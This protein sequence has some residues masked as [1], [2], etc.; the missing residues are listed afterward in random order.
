MSHRASIDPG[1]AGTG[2]CIWEE[3]DW[4]KQ[5]LPVLVHNYY[6][7]GAIPKGKFGWQTK[8]LRIA[9]DVADVL[10]EFEVTRVYCEFPELFQSAGGLMVAAR[11]DLQKLTFIVGCFAQVCAERSIKFKTYYPMDWKGNLKKEIIETRLKQRMPGLKKM[12][13]TLHGWDA[14]GIGLHAKG[15]FGPEGK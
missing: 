5:S 6:G 14:V 8:A 7:S 4:H 3:A 15:F 9:K 13:I 1:V 12:G 10:E 2:L 11:G